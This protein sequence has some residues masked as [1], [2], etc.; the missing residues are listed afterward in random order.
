MNNQE[1]IKEL[2]KKK[3][4]LIIEFEKNISAISNTI[5]ILKYEASQQQNLLEKL[6]KQQVVI[7]DNTDFLRM[8]GESIAE[9]ILNVIISKGRFLHNS[10]ITEILSKIYLGKDRKKLSRQISGQLSQL[11]VNN[12]IASFSDGLSQ[13]KIYWGFDKWLKDNKISEGFEFYKI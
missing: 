2:E 13:K 4:Q 10:E 6:S 12:K 1:L 11:K 7:E 8:K 9:T 5:Q 3:S